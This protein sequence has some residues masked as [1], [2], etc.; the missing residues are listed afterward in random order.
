MDYTGRGFITRQ[1]FF[2]SLVDIKNSI[3][4]EQIDAFFRHAQIFQ[5]SAPLTF[6]KFLKVFFPSIQADEDRE[7]PAAAETHHSALGSLLASAQTN[8]VRQSIDERLKNAEELVKNK[9]LSNYKTARRAFLE[10]DRNFDGFIESEDVAVRVMNCGNVAEG[11]LRLLFKMKSSRTDGKL[12]FNDFIKWFGTVI[13]PP[14]Q[15]YFRHDDSRPGEQ[16]AFA[17]PRAAAKGF[18]AATSLLTSN[19]EIAKKLKNI[20]HQHWKSVKRAFMDMKKENSHFV[21]K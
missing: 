14:S 2:A 10:L 7:D 16:K 8:G 9:L 13:D 20:F 11:D 1:N 4:E 18:K 6:S 12:S 15:F 17:N 3:P 5:D 21:D 19:Q